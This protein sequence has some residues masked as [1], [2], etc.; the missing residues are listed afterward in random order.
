M[1]M[2]F[3]SNQRELKTLQDNIFLDL[4]KMISQVSMVNG[5]QVR[6]F[7]Q[8]LSAYTGARHCI[9]VGNGT[10]ALIVSLMAAG[11]GSGDEVIVPCYS[12]FA[13]VSCV[14][15]VGATPVFVDIESTTYSMDVDQV[16]KAITSRTKAIMPV[17]LFC[18][19]A[20]MPRLKALADQYDILLIEDSA[21]AI[22]MFQQSTHAGL[23]GLGGT[24]SFFPT[25][26]LGAL[27][28]AGAILTH[29]EEF[30]QRC[31]LIRNL[32]RDDAGIAQ[33]VGVNSRMDDWQAVV[34]RHRL[35]I[36]NQVIAKRV[37]IAES[38]NNGLRKIEQ[39]ELVPTFISRGYDA[40]PVYYV[41]LLEVQ[42]RNQLVQHLAD[43]G[44]FSEIYYPIPLHLQPVCKKLGYA[45]GDFPNAEAIA[46]RVIGLPMYPEMA[47][48]EVDYLINTIIGF[49][50]S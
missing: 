50:E 26:T 17:H 41:Y 49:Y 9:A 39:V 42:R 20:D 46:E 37:Q 27:G 35:A 15:H 24:L 47:E 19:M 44:I 43:H 5:E 34:L 11:V 28:D 4:Q 32:G 7:E 30:A 12:F 10:D 16:K 36:L 14:L 18:Q 13:S 40:T 31:H 1:E 38:L 3:Y 33:C 29:S 23:F 8:E 21:E 25:K 2:P 6:L 45:E 22:G 48:N